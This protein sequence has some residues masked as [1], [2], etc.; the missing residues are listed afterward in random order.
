MNVL[1]PFQCYLVNKLLVQSSYII[2]KILLS[3]NCIYSQQTNHIGHVHKKGME[4]S[5]CMQYI[6]VLIKSFTALISCIM[7]LLF[8]RTRRRATYLC[9]KRERIVQL[10][11]GTPNL[12]LEK[13]VHDLKMN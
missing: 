4:R 9:L 10:Q 5:G 1:H 7:V 6:C 11:I 13:G 2:L 3:A 8:S 12:G